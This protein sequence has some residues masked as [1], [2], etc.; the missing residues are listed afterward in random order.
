MTNHFAKRWDHK[1]RIKDIIENAPDLPSAKDVA[2]LAKQVAER[3]EK[4]RDTIDESNALW[5][6][7]DGCIEDFAELA[8]IDNAYE[9]RAKFDAALHRLYDEADAGKRVWIE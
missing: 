5:A 9:A 6:D 8:D 4:F 3:L 1:L 7:I 2:G